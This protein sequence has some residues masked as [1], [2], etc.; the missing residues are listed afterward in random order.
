MFN[1]TSLSEFLGHFRDFGMFLGVPSGVYFSWGK[2]LFRLQFCRLF[3]NPSCIYTMYDTDDKT[4]QNFIESVSGFNRFSRYRSTSIEDM[5][6][7][8][9]ESTSAVWLSCS[10]FSPNL[11]LV[12]H[13]ADYF[14]NRRKPVT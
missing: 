12:H 9:S 3:S 14:R 8:G 13:I 5:G 1:K 10:T 7:V 11:W 2:N 6:G 4:E